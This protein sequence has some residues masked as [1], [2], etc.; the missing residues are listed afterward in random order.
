MSSPY[1]NC[2]EVTLQCPVSATTYGYIPNL[3]SNLILVIIFA[4]CTLA[5]A[6][7]AVRY[8]TWAFGIAATTGC[9]LECLGYIGR[10]M[11]H[12]KVWN[13]SALALQLVT[14]IVAP[15]FLAA[16]IY[17][18]LKHLVRHFGAQY[19]RLRPVLYVWI[20]VCSD[21][22]CIALQAVGGGIAAG[23]DDADQI[24]TGN[25]MIIAGLA[26]QVAVMSLC[27][28]LAANFTFDACMGRVVREPSREA[29]EAETPVEGLRFF[30]S[31]ICLAFLT[32][33]VRSAYR[34]PELADGWGSAL[35]RDE[36]DFMLLDGMMV[37]IA[38]VLITVAHPG[39]FFL[40]MRPEGRKEGKVAAYDKGHGLVE[41]A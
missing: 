11:L 30:L 37:A 1:K 38:A 19:S 16:A 34:V 35:M 25:D 21:V 41:M 40:A 5:Q 29:N 10:V 28:L 32:I 20:F 22:A 36:L 9:F 6:G 4:I 26:I 27:V 18:T 12:D 23:A 39:I 13:H 17:V 7:L 15:S 33:Y 3:P 8:R 14:L 31:C 24:T 2:T